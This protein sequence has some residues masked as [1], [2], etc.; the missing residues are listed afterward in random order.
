[1]SSSG[2]KGF[3]NPLTQRTAPEEEDVR[4]GA[5]TLASAPPALPAAPPPERAVPQAVPAASLPERAAPQAALSLPSALPA[6]ESQGS[7]AGQV[8]ARNR[9][10][11]FESR[12]VRATWWVNKGLRRKFDQL[13]KQTGITKTSLLNEALEDLLKKYTTQ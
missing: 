1:M 4:P 3:I 13:S 9:R 11:A 7:A 10:E 5:S 6:S 12:N 2:R 8:I